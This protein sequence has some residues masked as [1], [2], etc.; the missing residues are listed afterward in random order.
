MA[1]SIAVTNG[2]FSKGAPLGVGLTVALFASAVT[3]VVPGA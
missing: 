2:V 1:K 3:G